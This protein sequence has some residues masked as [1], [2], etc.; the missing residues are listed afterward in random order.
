MAGKYKFLL[1]SIIVLRQ[2][3][4]PKSS[5]NK[6]YTN[7]ILAYNKYLTTIISY[8]SETIS[9]NA[10]P[11]RENELSRCGAVLNR[12]IVCIYYT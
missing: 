9:I 5:Y 2:I 1:I 12:Y 4:F 3:Q 8:L 7:T 11:H 10:A 6:S